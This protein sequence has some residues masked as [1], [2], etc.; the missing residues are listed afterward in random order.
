MFTIIFS[1]FSSIRQGTETAPLDIALEKHGPIDPH[2]DPGKWVV[3]GSSEFA[4]YVAA[5][6]TFLA[7]QHQ[8]RE[9]RMTVWRRRQ[10]PANSSP[11]NREKY[12]ETFAEELILSHVSP[13]T[14]RPSGSY[15][16]YID[17]GISS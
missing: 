3:I 12:R 4:N 9:M 17:G 6:S 5:K 1:L 16:H 2:W 7:E 11:L 14:A 10:S 8:E 15:S 13:G